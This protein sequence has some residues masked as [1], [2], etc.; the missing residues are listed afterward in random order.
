MK[1]RNIIIVGVEE[2]TIGGIRNWKKWLKVDDKQ[3][4]K[5]YI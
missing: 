2:S 3:F 4:L 5:K 1:V